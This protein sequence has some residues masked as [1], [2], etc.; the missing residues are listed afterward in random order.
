MYPCP[1]LSVPQRLPFLCGQIGLFLFIPKAYPALCLLCQVT[2][3][4]LSHRHTQDF[5]SLG[6]PCVS[7]PQWFPAHLGPSSSNTAA[8]CLVPPILNPLTRPN[9]FHLMSC[10]LLL[11]F[12]L[13][14]ALSFL[15]PYA[16][17]CTS[18]FPKS[19]APN[20]QLIRVYSRKQPELENMVVWI[21]MPCPP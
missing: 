14:S 11:N 15:T 13:R 2:W 20:K 1:P 17:K 3:S 6:R 10:P 16:P 5:S 9:S 7:L 21:G 4:F 19:S 18:N 8:D 12:S